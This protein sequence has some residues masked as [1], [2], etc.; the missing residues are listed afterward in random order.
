MTA[1]HP[2]INEHVLTCLVADDIGQNFPGVSER[3]PL[4]R[5]TALN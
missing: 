2:Q 5:Q 4:C 1:A 3:I